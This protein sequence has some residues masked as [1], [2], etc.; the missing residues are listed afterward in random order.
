MAINKKLIHF[1]TFK[2]FNAK[3]LSANKENTAYTVGIDN[4]I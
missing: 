3:K 2:N 4:F 1:K